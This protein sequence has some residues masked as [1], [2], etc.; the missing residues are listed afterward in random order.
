MK[1]TVL[2]LILVTFST[3]LFSN[4]CLAQKIISNTNIVQIEVQIPVVVNEDCVPS[5]YSPGSLFLTCEYEIGFKPKAPFTYT[6]NSDSD[7]YY[8]YEFEIVGQK[9]VL[10][11]IDSAWIDDDFKA[12]DELV[13]KSEVINYFSKNKA[14]ITLLYT[15]PDPI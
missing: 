9:L 11:F 15:G 14:K 12:G 3:L 8:E 7:L 1:Y 4:L 2:K 5:F 6:I 13:F 10:T